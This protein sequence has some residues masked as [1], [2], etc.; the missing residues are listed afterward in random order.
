M[1]MLTCNHDRETGG[2]GVQKGAEEA[3]W[4]PVSKIK[5]SNK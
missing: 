4:Y 3:A 1:L 5:T 2:V